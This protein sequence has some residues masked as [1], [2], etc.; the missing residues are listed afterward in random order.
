MIHTGTP[1]VTTIIPTYRRPNLLK[2][3]IRS[4]LRQKYTNLQVL[5][6]DDCSSDETEAVVRAL[7][8]ED[9]R[10]IYMRH[11][12]NIGQTANWIYGMEQVNTPFF[13]FLSDDDFLLPDF[14]GAAISCLTNNPE[15]MF[16]CGSTFRVNNNHEVLSVSTSGWREG[17][18]RP[19]SGFFEMLNHTLSWNG[20]LFRREIIEHLGILRPMI[21]TDFDYL[22]RASIEHSY[23]VSK[24]PCA[25]F[26]VHTSNTW[27]YIDVNR[28][29]QDFLD[30]AI[31]VLNMIPAEW[32]AQ[33]WLDLSSHNFQGLINVFWSQIRD[34]L[35]TEAME[36]SRL[37]RLQKNGATKAYI[38]SLLPHLSRLGLFRKIVVKWLQHQSVILV[39]NQKQYLCVSKYLVELETV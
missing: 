16:F 18:H 10:V 37:L 29:Y 8:R 35:L 34:E 24:M 5:V 26:L 23:Y 2:R 25:G 9:R 27:W 1:L 13:S 14:Y 39:R 20:I 3:A 21:S 17:M 7:A 11:T 12:Q 38:L 31:T 6:L 30:T 36:T 32:R 19:P 22:I 28:S 15:A 4:V 33:A